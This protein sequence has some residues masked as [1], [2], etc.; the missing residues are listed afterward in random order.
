MRAQISLGQ[1]WSAVPAP[2]CPARWPSWHP[3][4]RCAAAWSFA[5]MYAHA[6]PFQM[7]ITISANDRAVNAWRDRLVAAGIALM[8]INVERDPLLTQ[9][10]FLRVVAGLAA[11]LLV[12]ER[13]QIVRPDEQCQ[14][15]F[16]ECEVEVSHR[17]EPADDPHRSHDGAVVDRFACDLYLV[18]HAEHLLRECR[19]R[20]PI[21]RASLA[22]GIQ[23][24][25][26]A[27]RIPRPAS[28]RSE[29]LHHQAARPEQICELGPLV[30]VQE[31]V[32][33]LHGLAHLPL[34]ALGALGSKRPGF[35]RFGAIKCFALG[36]FRQQAHGATV[37]HFRLR[38]LDLQLIQNG[39]ELLDLAF[40]EL[41]LPRQEAERTADSKARRLRETREVVVLELSEGLARAP[42]AGTTVGARR[43]HGGTAHRLFLL[44]PGLDHARR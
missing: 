2:R 31:R 44:A 32:Q 25:P 3:V 42:G 12:Q 16:S 11:R 26:R 10:V 29:S 4:A 38:P 36:G 13:A 24:Y 39:G 17:E 41:E 40:V 28:V 23:K 22:K 9:G 21:A 7:L 37:I 27:G 6:G 5:Q 19:P 20:N 35:V 15:A 8:A 30:G 43:K 14:E 34:D 33:A 18:R 1:A